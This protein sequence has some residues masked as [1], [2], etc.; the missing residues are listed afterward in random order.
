MKKWICING[1]DDSTCFA[2]ELDEKELSAI[3]RFQELAEQTSTYGCMPTIEIEDYA[4][5]DREDY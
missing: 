2:M 5:Q 4:D 3:Y 1:C